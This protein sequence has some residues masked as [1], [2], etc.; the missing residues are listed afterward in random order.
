VAH[1]AFGL[2]IEEVPVH[3]VRRQGLQG[4]GRD[5]GLGAAG[6]DH[7]HVGPARLQ[8]AHEE[9]GLVG[10]DAAADA[11]DDIAIEKMCHR[12]PRAGKIGR[13]KGRK[14]AQ[15]SPPDT[16]HCKPREGLPHGDR[17]LAAGRGAA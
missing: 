6:H 8:F 17:R 15:G 4:E 5:E 11:K 3:R 2:L 12:G 1:A 7:P 14:I 16:V 13:V 9:G 10:G